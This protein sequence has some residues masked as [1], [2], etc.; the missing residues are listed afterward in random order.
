MKDFGCEFLRILRRSFMNKQ[1]AQ[2]YVSVTHIGAKDV[3]TKEIVKM[4]SGRMLFKK[5]TML[6]SRASKGAVAVDYRRNA[7]R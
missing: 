7:R 2:F 3:L 4:A 5:R 6:M 1:I